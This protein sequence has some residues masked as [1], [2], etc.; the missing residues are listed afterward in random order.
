M[1]II[2]LAIFILSIGSCKKTETSIPPEMTS[3]SIKELA[4]TFTLDGYQWNSEITT[5]ED[6]TSLTAQFS[7]SKNSEIYI[8]STIQI[9]EYTKNDFSKPVTYKVTSTNGQS[10]NYTVNLVAN[11]PENRSP[12]SDPGP[13]KDLFSSTDMLSV[14]LD[15]SLSSD[16]D[17][18]IVAYRWYNGTTLIG[19]GINISIEL[20]IGTHNITLQVED[21]RGG[22]SDSDL[23]INI[24]Q[25]GEH[26]PVDK[27]AT[28]ETIALY[29]NIAKIAY[30]DKFMFGQEHPITYRLNSIRYDLSS[31]DC[32]DVT[33]DHPAVYGIDPHYMLYKS[34]KE[35]QAHIEEA[36][37]AYNT[38][39]VV[40]F[41]FHQQS[42]SDHKIYMAD[43][44]TESDKSLMYDVVNNIGTSREWF[45]EEL[46]QIV[47]IINNDLNF[48]VIF[49]LYHEMD[50]GWFWWGSSAKNHSASLYIE[51]YR[52]AADHIKDRSNLILFAWSP[53]SYVQDSYYPGNDYVD[54]VGFDLYEPKKED[55]KSRLIDLTDFAK[56]HNKI[57][58]L[59]ETGDRSDYINTNPNFWTSEILGAIE[60]GQNDISIAWVLSWF[61]APWA[62]SQSDLF[63]P[64]SDSPSAAKD[65]FINFK[66]SSTTLFQSDI[67][68]L[69]LYK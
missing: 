48:P 8:G 59:S 32:K 21:N 1:K 46:D 40:T 26:S 66:N 65:D 54:F 51:L 55:L 47:D 29:K 7:V 30:S 57:A 11:L 22:V 63:I 49:R 41:D 69:E 25:L 64:N 17:G 9:S 13:N 31:S 36:K 34:D 39:A 38:G 44:T 10:A 53:N 15:G 33:G 2:L 58:I 62:G 37:L 20:A 52:L 60:E 43:I 28:A 56:E 50:G 3:F 12:K 68:R 14:T 45:F 61:N 19:E 16:S 27:E 24:G 5:T 42:R 67:K 35:K 23:V 6:L 4:T 18:T